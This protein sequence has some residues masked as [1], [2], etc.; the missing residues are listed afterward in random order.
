MCKAIETFLEREKNF[1]R[2]KR[3]DMERWKRYQL[4]DEALSHENAAAWLENL[5]QVTSCPK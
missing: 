4:T 5:A 1:E 3:E 2:E